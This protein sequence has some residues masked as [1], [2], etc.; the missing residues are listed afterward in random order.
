MSNLKVELLTF[1][2]YLIITFCFCFV[3]YLI[4]PAPDLFQQNFIVEKDV[5]TRL[6]AHAASLSTQWLFTLD[7]SVS[8]SIRIAAFP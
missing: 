4:P 5:F 1:W 2:L 6:Q 7:E 3:F 8:H